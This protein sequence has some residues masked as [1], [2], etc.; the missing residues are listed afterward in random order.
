[1]KKEVF[2]YIH[3]WENESG[4][5]VF[6]TIPMIH[7]GSPKYYAEVSA[8]I[9][10]TNM[11]LEEGV[12]S[13]IDKELGTYNW[14]AKKLGLVS[15]SSSMKID[16]DIKRENIDIGKNEFDEGFSEISVIERVKIKFY[17]YIMLFVS[18]QKM[19]EL[20]YLCFGYSGEAWLKLVDPSQHYAYKHDKTPF[21]LLITNTRDEYVK[22]NLQS[23]IDK[24]ID[25]EYQYNIAIQFGDE[26]MPIIYSVLKENGFKWKL[27]KKINV[28]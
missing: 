14:I 10:S 12:P 27:E 6:I 5:L 25:R 28:F 26:H 1:M 23:M 3:S 13:K 11:L 22:K 7:I 17:K 9:N 8:L 4:N 18:K 16:D 15:Q 24:N 2:R 20:L 19:F 21:D